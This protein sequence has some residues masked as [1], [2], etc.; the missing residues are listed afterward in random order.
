MAKAL[1]SGVKIEGVLTG[2]MNYEAN[3]VKGE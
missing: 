2:M 1:R 3:L